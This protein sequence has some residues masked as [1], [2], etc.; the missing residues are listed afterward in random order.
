[1]K[2]LLCILLSLSTLLFT[3]CSINNDSIRFGA[4]GIGGMYYS[5]AG[6]FAE[7]ASKN[8]SDLN[9]DVKSTAGSAAN[10]RLLSGGYIEMGIAQTDLLD[11]AYHGTGTF[12][13]KEIQGYKAIAGL[14]T[15]ACQLVVLKNSGL[16]SLDDLQ[17][18][19]VS[20]GESDSGTERNAKQILEMSG[21][22][23]KL[24]KMVNLDYT[25]SAKQLE[26]GKIDAFFCTAGTRTTVI[27]ELAQQCDISF[28]SIDNKCAN[29]LKSVYKFYTDYTIP[30]GTYSG[31]NEDV[32]TVGIQSV[33]L[34]SDKLSDDTVKELTAI[35]FEHTKDIQYSTPV[36]L[37]LN[38]ESAIEGITI[39]FHPGAAS[40]YA[41]QGINVSTE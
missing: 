29:K 37:Q 11:D 3:G 9:F 38:V 33:L 28:I 4:A 20:I 41:E 13:N 25:D 16:T 17:G 19:I 18:K 39:P 2:R 7:I 1:M 12:N 35:L 36:N 30:A 32:H 40:Y 34:A 21:L 14:Y 27:E 22:N 6:S 10:L 15:E 8:D 23:S 26:S 24:V 5:F 31:Q